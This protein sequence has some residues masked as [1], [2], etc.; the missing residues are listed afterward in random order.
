MELS[1]SLNDHNDQDKT[2]STSE[3]KSPETENWSSLLNNL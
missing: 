2:D 1:P 3:D